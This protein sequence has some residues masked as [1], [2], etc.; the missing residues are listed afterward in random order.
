MSNCWK[1]PQKV[2]LYYLFHRAQANFHQLSVHD[3]G[4]FDYR[5]RFSS[6][7]MVKE[8]AR[9]DAKQVDLLT[10]LCVGAPGRAIS[11]RSW[12]LS[13]CVLT[14]CRIQPNV[15]EMAALTGKWGSGAAAGRIARAAFAWPFTAVSSVN[16]NWQTLVP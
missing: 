9:F 16:K 14:T 4:W 1:S 8:M 11:L 15:S 3:A 6:W 5:L 10:Q 2:P 13:S 7:T 12:M